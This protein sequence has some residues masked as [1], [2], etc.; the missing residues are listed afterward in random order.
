M[1]TYFAVS[2][3]GLSIF[4]AL[5][6]TY[7]VNEKLANKIFWLFLAA[8]TVPSLLLILFQSFFRY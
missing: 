5:L 4:A 1:F 6:L 8:L 3:L 2:F 7:V